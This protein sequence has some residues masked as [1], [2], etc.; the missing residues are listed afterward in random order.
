MLKGVRN[1]WNWSFLVKELL[2]GNVFYIFQLLLDFS[3]FPRFLVF[4]F[5]PF[6]GNSTQD[7]FKAAWSSHKSVHVKAQLS[8]IANSL[9]GDQNSD[10][11]S[12]GWLYCVKKGQ[13]RTA[14]LPHFDWTG[15]VTKSSSNVILCFL[16]SSFWY[17]SNHNSYI[18]MFIRYCVLFMLLSLFALCRP[19]KQYPISTKRFVPA[20]I[21]KPDWAIDVSH[22]D[23]VM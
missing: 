10:L 19:L 3:S 7:C 23:F 8:S 20:E 11:I 18:H 17:K 21:E 14:K 1:A 6:C 9:P 16:C 15:F 2:S 22:C 13:A 5:F 12:Q 4:L